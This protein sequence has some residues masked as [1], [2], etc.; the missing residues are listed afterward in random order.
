LKLL[1]T[2]AQK[3]KKKKK[4]KKRKKKTIRKGRGGWEKEKISEGHPTPRFATM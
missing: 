2:P 4:K 3:K 1:H